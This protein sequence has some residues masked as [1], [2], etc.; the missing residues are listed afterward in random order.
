[1][2]SSIG[3]GDS[4][5]LSLPATI[6]PYHSEEQQPRK[7][8]ELLTVPTHS[9]V[10][11]PAQDLVVGSDQ[12]AVTFVNRCKEFMDTE[13]SIRKDLLDSWLQKLNEFTMKSAVDV[14]PEFYPLKNFI[15]YSYCLFRTD[16]SYS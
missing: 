14:S 10:I 13:N 11:Q 6:P 16:H 5:S 2:Y 1:M 12:E 15:T 4:Q 8:T 3:P 9:P 7:T